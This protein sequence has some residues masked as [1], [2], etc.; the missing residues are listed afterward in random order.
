MTTIQGGEF[1]MSTSSPEVTRPVSVGTSLGNAS[2]GIREGIAHGRE[3]LA[4]K[5]EAVAHAAKV[6]AAVKDAWSDTK[7]T[8]QDKIG[9]ATR[10]LHS[11]KQAVQG[12]ASGL[13]QQARELTE[14]AHAQVPEPVAGRVDQ[15]S[16]VVRQRPVP[17][18]AIMLA[19]LALLLLRRWIPR[20]RRTT[21][22]DQ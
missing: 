1:T 5:V 19:V 17:M 14:Q 11:G 7:N 8:V 22:S 2:Q 21:P 9:Q 16:Q 10:R 6:P 18:A 13:A 12:S 20:D 4:G 3:Q 15:L